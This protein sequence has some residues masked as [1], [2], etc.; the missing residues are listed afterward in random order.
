MD[1]I[2][3]PLTPFAAPIAG[4]YEVKQLLGRG[5]MGDVFSGVDLVLERPVA[6]KVLRGTFAGDREALT[7]FGREARTVASFDHPGF[8]T[9][10]DVVEEQGVPIIVMEL[11]QGHSLEQLLAREGSISWGRAVQIVAS[12]AETIAVAHDAGVVHR[13]LKPGNIMIA[14]EGTVKVLD[15]G[16]ARVNALTPIASSGALHG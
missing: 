11:V 6:I 10:F 1:D 5:G 15:F 14:E 9:V 8:A 16:I 12:V 7:R 2:P 3:Y 4:R 13:D